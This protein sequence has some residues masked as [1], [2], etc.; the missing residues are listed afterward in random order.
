MPTRDAGETEHEVTRIF[1]AHGVP[2][3]DASLV[4]SELVRTELMG[5]RSHGLIRVSQ[6]L[7]DIASGLVRPGEP[8]TALDDQGVTAIVDC[9]WNLG[10]VAAHQA[11]AVGIE[12]ARLHRMAAVVTRKCNH[13]G[14]LGSYAERGGPVWPDLHCGD[15]D[16]PARA[17]RRTVWGR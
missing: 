3:A 8:V 1:M 13:A 5:M 12:R 6:Y 10:I 4:A 17:F 7:R 9:G 14:R 11:L 2:E 16:P 15:R